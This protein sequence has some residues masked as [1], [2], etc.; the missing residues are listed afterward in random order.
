MRRSN[1]LPGCSMLD[2]HMELEGARWK[3]W[4]LCPQDVQL[5]RLNKMSSS[6]STL[7]VAARLIQQEDAK[8]RKTEI[9]HQT[10][11]VHWWAEKQQLTWYDFIEKYIAN[12][13]TSYF[14]IKFQKKTDMSTHYPVSHLQSIQ[15]SLLAKKTVH[16]YTKK[17][18]L[19]PL[20]HVSII[21][22]CYIGLIIMEIRLRE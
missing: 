16:C 5:H 20:S 4:G 18:G 2:Q 19:S 14:V 7:Y 15:T 8:N 3:R 11:N 9:W 10:S 17:N 1:V 21:Q 6:S 12:W 22:P 13:K